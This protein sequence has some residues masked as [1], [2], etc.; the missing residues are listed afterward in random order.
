MKKLIFILGMSISAYSQ[1]DSS[2]TETKPPSWE[3]SFTWGANISHTLN[4]NAPAG[5]PRQGLA[6]SNAVDIIFNYVKEE[7]RFR[8]T[9]ELHWLF[10]LGK[11]DARSRTLTTADQFFT[12]HDLSYSLSK[13]GKWSANLILKTDSPIFKQYEGNFMKDYYQLGPIRSFLNPYTLVVSPG[14]RYQIAPKN[15]ISLSPYSTEIFG[16]TNQFIA[17]KGN[18]IS[19]RRPDGHYKTRRVSPNGTELNIWLNKKIAKRLDFDY[20]LG[21]RYNFFTSEALKGNMK[22]MFITNFRIMKGLKLSHRASLNGPI[23]NSIPYRPFY[24]QTVLL[25][26][27]LSL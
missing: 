2:Q 27:S 25:S 22:G 16:L 26:Y 18:D 20:K 19:E 10:T 17:D 23:D 6:Y 21:I 9:N 7:S 13:S 11:A 3:K 12:F 15:T 8:A 4:I 1:S 14:I 24:S 5:T